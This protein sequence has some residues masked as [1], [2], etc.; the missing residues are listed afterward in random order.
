MALT[1]K[2]MSDMASMMVGDGGRTYDAVRIHQL[3]SQSFLYDKG[4]VREDALDTTSPTVAYFTSIAERMAAML[5]SKFPEFKTENP[6]V[7]KLI[8]QHTVMLDGVFYE[9]IRQYVLYGACCVYFDEAIPKITVL[10]H[11]AY[12]YDVDTPTY[13]ALEGS[14]D[15]EAHVEL[16][17]AHGVEAGATVKM[18]YTTDTDTGTGCKVMEAQGKTYDLGSSNNG[19]WCILVDD[20]RPAVLQVL[21]QLRILERL[22]DKYLDTTTALR[23]VAVGMASSERE[24]RQVLGQDFS[25]VLLKAQATYN[26]VDVNKIFQYMDN[27]PISTTLAQQKQEIEQ[28]KQDVLNTLNMAEALAGMTDNANESRIAASDRIQR[29]AVVWRARQNQINNYIEGIIRQFV[30]LYLG[31][32][33][34]TLDIELSSM[35]ILA[36]EVEEQRREAESASILGLLQQAS[37]MAQSG[38]A[39]SIGVVKAMILAN[40]SSDVHESILHATMTALDTMTA[41]VMER[42]NT[43]PEPP[44]PT[45]EQ[46]LVQAQAT[47]AEAEAAKVQSDMVLQQQKADLEQ[48]Q[49][50]QKA[51][52]D[53]QRMEMEADQAKVDMATKEVALQGKQLEAEAKAAQAVEADIEAADAMRGD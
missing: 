50:Q 38:D 13:F 10:P 24:I 19:S 23:V 2:Q 29:A 27:T 4:Y 36:K 35:N 45:P 43:P 44:A 46:Q 16:L 17:R 41:G 3:L 51:M 9:A 40:S 28:I 39:E 21:P 5:Y 6:Q 22:Y 8:E 53:A 42:R 14:I 15:D 25:V 32:D 49:A 11:D 7:T 30:G 26:N 47:K 37:Q 52:I 48:Q 12:S 1:S 18:Y 31:V 20:T 33:V 34:S